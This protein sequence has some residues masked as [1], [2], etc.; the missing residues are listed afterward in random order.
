M[1]LPTP[2]RIVATKQYHLPGSH[3]EIGET[4]EELARVNIIRPAHSPYTSLV[5]PVQKQDGTCCIT[6]DY[7]ELNKVIPPFFAV[8]PNITKLLDQLS[9]ELGTYHYVLG[10]ANAYFLY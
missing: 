9:H 2:C 6:V 7:R 1:S 3:K 5:Q 10:L 4:I 8:V